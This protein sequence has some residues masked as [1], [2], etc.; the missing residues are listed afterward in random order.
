MNPYLMVLLADA[1]LAASFVSQ[2][3]YQNLA[4]ALMKAGLWYNL[5]LGMVSVAYYLL[6]SR[7]SV[8]LTV[9]SV[10]M[11]ALFTSF[12]LAYSIVG[13]KIMETGNM[14][15]HTLFLMVGGMVVP[16]IYGVMFLDEALSP[17]RIVGVLAIVIAIAVIHVG[18][19]KPDVRQLLL[20][21]A[22]FFLNGFVSVISKIHQISP[23][24]QVVTSSD[25]ALITA[26]F[27][28]F[29]SA[30]VL[31]VFKQKLHSQCVTVVTIKKALPL[32][33]VAAVAV[34]ISS[35]LQLSGATVLD[36]S[37][38]YPLIT[39]GTIVVTTI[40]DVLV[41][42]TKMALRQWLAVAICF[43]GTLLFL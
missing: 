9:Y 8:H 5:L 1:L 25:F 22:V 3:K 21:V 2:K 10:V 23:A 30:I 33:V 43:V 15:L 31:L 11:A 16:Y 29:F 18:G 12:V 14:S 24:S 34:S 13:F 19:K 38:L 35:V 6:V 40:T 36:A 37:V 39:G 17:T 20:C 7:L 32:I 28:F 4:G 42:K 27:K 26:F 41:F